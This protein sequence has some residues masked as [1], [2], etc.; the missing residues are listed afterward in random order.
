M[1]ISK[2]LGPVDVLSL[3]LCSLNISVVSWRSFLNFRCGFSDVIPSSTLSHFLWFHFPGSS[4]RFDANWFFYFAFVLSTNSYLLHLSSYF[5]PHSAFLCLCAYFILTTFL[6]C[7]FTYCNGCDS[8]WFLILP[9]Q[10]FLS[11][12]LYSRFSLYFPHPLVPL[13][14]CSECADF[15][16]WQS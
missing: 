8:D 13:F 11:L 5:A 9:F 3:G 7:L 16:L 12:F 10:S 4:D 1:D 15:Q 14:A 6:L 2:L